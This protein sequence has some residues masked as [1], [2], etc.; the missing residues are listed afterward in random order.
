MKKLSGPLILAFVLLIGLAIAVSRAGAMD[1]DL[2]AANESEQQSGNSETQP[3]PAVLVFQEL[4]NKALAKFSEGWLYMR[5]SQTH[6]VDS[7]K[8]EGEFSLVD[9]TTDYWYYLNASGYVERFVTI[10]RTMDGQ[11]QQVGIYS[12]GTAWNTMVDE[13]ELMESFFFEGFDYGL[14]YGFKSPD[15]SSNNIILDNGSEAV[16]FT[17]TLKDEEPISAFFYS[18]SARLVSTAYEYIFDST[19]GFFVS[20]RVIVRLEDGT[21]RVFL[22]VQR[23]EIKLNVEPP[24]EVLK[25]FEIKKD[26]EEQK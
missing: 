1:R 4:K 2:Q 13:I 26:R 11:I 17:Y 15:F 24:A 8:N 23:E 19:T 5:D 16:E 12:D 25:Y 3:P 18:S 10:T 14:P 6:D 22:Y 20:E 7:P 21:Q 9:T